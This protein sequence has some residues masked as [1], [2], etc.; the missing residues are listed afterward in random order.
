VNGVAMQFRPE[1]SRQAGLQP[2]KK[3]V[4]LAK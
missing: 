4:E 3:L 1:K 2:L